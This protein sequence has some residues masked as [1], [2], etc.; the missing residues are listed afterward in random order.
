M[1]FQREMAGVVE[2]NT[3]LRLISLERIGARI[4]LV[5]WQKI[6]SHSRAEETFVPQT[7]DGAPHWGYRS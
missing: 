5:S 4:P 1:C 6:T 3:G 2:M 7:G